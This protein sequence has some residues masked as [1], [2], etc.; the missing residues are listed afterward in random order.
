MEILKS[1]AEEQLSLVQR[2][3]NISAL[4]A[5]LEFGRWIKVPAIMLGEARNNFRAAQT[6]GSGCAR[7]HA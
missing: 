4:Q 5:A 1:A 7:R 3:D 6:H 2:G